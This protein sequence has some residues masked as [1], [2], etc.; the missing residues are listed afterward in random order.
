VKRCVCQHRRSSRTT[1]LQRIETAAP[2]M[3]GAST[4]VWP[5][6]Q[7]QP[8]SD[9]RGV[10]NNLELDS[11]HSQTFRST[12]REM[13][14]RHQARLTCCHGIR[15]CRSR[16]PSYMLSDLHCGCHRLYPAAVVHCSC[17]RVVRCVRR[18]LHHLRSQPP[19]P[20]ADG[21][22]AAFGFLIILFSVDSE[23]PC[24]LNTN[25]C[26]VRYHIFTALPLQLSPP[27]HS[28]RSTP[29]MQGVALVTGGEG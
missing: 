4:C 25:L 3:T 10:G 16:E 8:I 22:V 21:L 27:S 5:R 17:Y 29:T 9:S 20:V 2:A 18:N 11:V 24:G 26:E 1:P 13:A 19:H 23:Q 7:R 28:Q 15:P 6:A 14:D 12:L